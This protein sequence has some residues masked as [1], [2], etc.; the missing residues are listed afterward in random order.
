MNIGERIKY[1]RKLRGM[2]QE[3]LAGKIGLT[4]DENG[5]TRISQYE[6]GNRTPKEDMLEKISDVLN[7]HS[8]YL[9]NKKHTAAL[10][11]AFTLFEYDNDLP[12]IIKKENGHYLLD[13]DNFIFD[14]FF[15]EWMQKKANLKNGIISKEEYIEWKLNYTGRD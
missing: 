11:F 13:L 10:N 5:R 3:E 9:S 1:V 7:V 12:I 15:E 4:A 6:N 8:L 14:D 2:K